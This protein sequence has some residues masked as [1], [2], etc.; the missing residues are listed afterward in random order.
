MKSISIN[1]RDN[2]VNAMLEKIRRGIKL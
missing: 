1:R 2:S